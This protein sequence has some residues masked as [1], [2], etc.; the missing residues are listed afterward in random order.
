MNQ[1]ATYKIRFFHGIKN[2][3]N[4]PIHSFRDINESDY[5]AIKSA[6]EY[7][8]FLTNLEKAYELIV[9]NYRDYELNNFS[10]I[11]NYETVGLNEAILRN[12]IT[13]IDRHISNILTSTYLYTCLLVPNKDI[14]KSVN[15]KSIKEKFKNISN[16]YH[17]THYQYTF[18]SALRNKINHGGSLQKYS[19]IGGVWSSLWDKSK[20]DECIQVL[21][22]D[23]R[24]S[25]LDMKVSGSEAKR[26]IDNAKHYA[27]IKNLMPDTFYLR[28]A[29][30][31]YI[32]LLST[33]HSELRIHR[34]TD[35]KESTDFINSYS[36]NLEKIVEATLIKYVSDNEQECSNLFPYYEEAYKNRDLVNAPLGLERYYMPGEYEDRSPIYKTAQ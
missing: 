2:L 9:F 17:S 3:K 36:V 5:L 8:L 26:I 1:K 18:M 14:E 24:F 22:K 10:I 7:Q 15:I 33:A 16:S 32:H 11:L 13:S 4:D 12:N 20:D 31:V 25:L 29:V 27:N 21:K 6:L 34:A 19:S 35:L 30:R 23:R 28:E